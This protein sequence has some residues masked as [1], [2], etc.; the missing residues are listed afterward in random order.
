ML[1]SN[2]LLT[3]KTMPSWSDIS[4]ALYKEFSEQYLIPTI[5]RY[6]LENREIID[7]LR[8]GQSIIFLEYSILME[9]FLK[10]N[11]LKKSKTDLI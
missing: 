6:Y 7:V 8:N 10:R 5:F 1:H 4:L 9:R 11:S 2:D 3:I